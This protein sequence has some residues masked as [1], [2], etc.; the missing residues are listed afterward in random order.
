V[1]NGCDAVYFGGARFNARAAAR[2]FDDTEILRAL[3]YC[4]IRGVKTYITVNT[5]YKQLE[6]TS[7]F[8]F[9]KTMY[10]YG[11]DA[12]IVQDIGAAFF[13]KECFPKAKLHASTQ[14]TAH[15][16]EDAAQLAAMG[17]HRI[18][19]SRELSLA[20]IEAITALGAA[21]TEVFVHGA[22]C[23]SY[24]G[25]C[26]MSAMLG[27]RSGNR[28]DCA[29]P[30]RRKYSL[31][32]DGTEVCAGHLLSPKDMAAPQVMARLAAAGVASFKIEG[33][34][35]SAEY[36][37][38]ATHVYRGVID[39][40]PLD[41]SD[42]RKLAQIFNRGGSFTA[43]YFEQFSGPGMMS[44]ETPKSSGL[45]IGRVFAYNAAA[46]KCQIKLEAPVRPGDGIEI[47]TRT[48]PHIGT[49]ISQAAEQGS[50][51]TVTLDGR[52][53]KG[54]RV[55]KSFDKTLADELKAAAARNGRRL[56]VSCAI[57]A[58]AGERLSVTLTKGIAAAVTGPAVQ[59]AVTSPLTEGELFL[60][61]A[62]IGDTPLVFKFE[63]CRID[64]GIFINI[65]EINRTRREAADL[66]LRK[67][68]ESFRRESGAQMPKASNL[69]IAPAET[70]MSVLVTTREQLDAALSA[71]GIGRVYL[72]YGLRG[73]LNYAKTSAAAGVK[74]FAA[75]PPIIRKGAARDILEALECAPA[76]AGT[77]CDGYLARTWGQLFML[78]N[79][80]TTKEIAAD[81]TFNIMNAEAAAQVLKYASTV[82]L[83]PELSRDDL[84]ALTAA[85]PHPWR[86]EVIVYGRQRVMV[87]HQCPA[88]L[89]TA[90]KSSGQYCSIRNRPGSC[91]LWDG[92]TKFLVLTDC[93]QCLAYIY[94]GRVICGSRVC[95][96]TGFRRLG[97]VDETA[98]QCR[99]M[100]RP[101]YVK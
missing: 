51:V 86:L 85:S 80:K 91:Y 25:Q 33:R 39:G 29:Q 41:E 62:K 40:S 58:V 60:R 38:L 98:A 88:G 23:V 17:F 26:L 90:G 67:Y 2:N 79:L 53:E 50:V 78:N 72:E 44:V 1:Q 61:L 75:L 59:R 11:A 71:P 21:E 81:C 94:S 8:G 77:S 64:K 76:G 73:Y 19:L 96:L 32:R 74:V 46:R 7:L 18:V 37:A 97:F 95:G 12:F 16:A 68:A 20:E 93:E 57:R 4:H 100:L 56:E 65:G 87:T 31:F 27:G 83:S 54:D 101:K 84:E 13:I 48:G 43:G 6:L 82:A 14:L 99:E 28:G 34:M 63:N 49:G 55:F 47:W 5:L 15:G 35:K 36:V 42:F 30:C 45:Y 24:S 69:R 70:A 22:L 66:F 9:L 89:Y 52:I 92:K 10:A 3:D